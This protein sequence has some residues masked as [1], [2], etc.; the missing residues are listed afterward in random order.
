LLKAVEG[1]Y[2]SGKVELSETPDGVEGARVIVTFLPI[3][4]RVD[5]AVRGIGT[6][7]AANLHARL[8]AFTEDWDLPEM[9]VY[10][11]L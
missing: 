2:R 5:L 7:Q 1:I 9:D 4:G 8:R 6:E 10:D 3:D 11:D